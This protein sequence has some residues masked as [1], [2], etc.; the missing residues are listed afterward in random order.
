MNLNN[1]N[2]FIQSSVKALFEEKFGYAPVLVRAPGR[3][4]LIGEHT[5]YNGGFVLPAAVDKEMV[6]ALGKNKSEQIRLVSHDLE[7]E[8]HL[9][10]GNYTHQKKNWANYLIG[11]MKM[12]EEAGYTLG[13]FDC[14]FGGN[15]PMGSGLSSSAAVECGLGYGLSQIF[16]FDLDKMELAKLAQKAENEF[17]G[18]KCG[19]M[20]QFASVHGITNHVMR[21]DCRSLEYEYFRFESTD[22]RILLLDTQVKHNLGSSEYNTRRGECEA[23][24][25]ILK[26]HHPY[27]ENLR[28]CTLEILEEHRTELTGKIYQRCQYVIEE[29]NRVVAACQSLEKNNIKRF[30]E[31]M[32]LSH[33]GLQHLYEV[34]CPELDFLVEQAR[35][36]PSIYGARMMGGG[37]GGCTINLVKDEGIDE[38]VQEIQVAY[39]KEF[40]INMLSHR[41][42]ISKGVSLIEDVSLMEL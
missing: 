35:L 20:D 41:T 32:Y 25:A 30:G 36:Y 17:V 40:K 31:L 3:V 14:C 1:P 9:V 8:L 21:L 6:F 24:V 11:V 2:K 13:G 18:V 5:D 42:K 12:L 26:K 28:D 33:H 34:S 27:I 15:I 16:G 29:N 7:E 22:F 10:L 37:F 4:N 19:I 38:M 23:G 39:R